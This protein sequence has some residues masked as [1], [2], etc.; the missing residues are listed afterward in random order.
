MPAN[1][2]LICA[3]TDDLR[4]QLEDQLAAGGYATTSVMRPAEAVAALRDKQYD[5]V[6]AEGLAVR[7][8][9]VLTSR[10]AQRTPAGMPADR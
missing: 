1:P 2:I 4:T 3:P 5:L 6:L 8:L 7:C 10:T 9:V